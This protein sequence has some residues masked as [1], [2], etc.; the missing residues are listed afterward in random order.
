VTS[1]RAFVSGAAAV[2][3]GSLQARARAQPSG[4]TPRVGLLVIADPEHHPIA[5]A[6]LDEFRNGM[7]DRG[8]VDGQT[9]AIE[10]RFASGPG[11][12][13]QDIVAELLRLKVDVLVV[14]ST[15]MAVAA[16]EVTTTL[17]IVGVL[18][19]PVRDG[20]V[21]SLA[22]PGGN[23][24]GVTFLGPALV[25]KRL[26]FLR[27]TLPGASHV[28]VLIHPGVYG[29]QT[30]RDMTAEAEVAGKALGM[31]LQFV[32][33]RT[34][35][36]LEKAFPAMVRGGA[37]ALTVFPS[38]MFYAEHRRIVDLA[39]AH[40]LPAIYAFREA[41]YLGGL[42]AYGTYIPGLFRA[43]ATFVDKILKGARPAELPVE[44]PTKFEFVVNL[45]AARVLGL[46]I[47]PSVLARADEVIQ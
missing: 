18:A 36:D 11:Q 47:P 15:P 19:D 32:E 43:T 21:A 46:T 9:V 5:R 13:F 24:T 22:R 1:R 29:D 16:R 38:P 14:A 34:P 35:G 39:T 26:Q 30:M 33:A 7:R 25:A 20:V 45:K 41:V 4:R 10:P 12:Q 44:Q 27:E 28:A 23:I 40:R 3:A 6:Q 31:Q 37:G 2:L 17:P 42:M 8:Y